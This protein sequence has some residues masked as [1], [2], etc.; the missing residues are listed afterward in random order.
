MAEHVYARIVAA[1]LRGQASYRTSFALQCVASALGQLVELAVILVL[2]SRVTALGGFGVDEVV[3]MYALA[4]VAFG[5]ADL[6]AGQLDELPAQIRTGAFDVVLLRPLSTLGQ[7]LTSEVH[8]RK[9]A[10]ILAGVAALVYA[11]ARND[12]AW[13]PLT[14]PLVVLAPLSGAVIFSAVW[15]IANAVCFWLVDG[16]QLANAVTHGGNAFASYPVT[17]YGPRL[18][19]FFTVVVPGAFI[20][21]YPALALLGRPDPLGGPAL[22]G[23][24]SPPVAAVAAVVAGLVW[25][26]AV[27]H[28]RGTGS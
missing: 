25:R 28:Y 7:V 1:R 2:F 4:G 16:Q 15:V 26:F 3:L 17:V 23:W 19:R 10:R 8:L 9:V 14:A 13:S 5:I 18:R 12:I 24:A 6:V 27:R 21:Y 11:L 22:L 20:A